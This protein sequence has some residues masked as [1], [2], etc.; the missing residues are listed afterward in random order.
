MAFGSLLVF[1]LPAERSKLTS[2]TNH[3]V[4]SYAYNVLVLYISSRM[5]GSE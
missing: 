2:T 1:R 4:I 3:R 5:R